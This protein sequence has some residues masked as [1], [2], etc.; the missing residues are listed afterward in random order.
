MQ[1]IYL[2]IVLSPLAAALVAGLFGKRIGRSGAHV[3]TILGVAVACALSV[4]V[5][6]QQLFGG[7]T[8]DNLSVYT[9][10]V[11]DGVRMEI[12]FLVDRLSAL[13]MV[14]V[15]SIRSCGRSKIRP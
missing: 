12:G 9:W 6:W 14:V 2:T 3:V 11:T 7:A 4:Y 8:T 15:S 10:L 5:L 13:M 1:A